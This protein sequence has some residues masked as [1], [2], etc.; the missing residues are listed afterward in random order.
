MPEVIV[1]Q[2]N[3]ARQEELKCRVGAY[4]R[5]SSDSDDQLNSFFNQVQHYT[6]LIKSNPEWEY[7]DIYAD[8]GVTGTRADKRSD[9]NRMI[10]DCEDGKLDK[11]ITKSISRFARNAV[12]CVKILKHLK[13]FGVSVIFEEDH[14][15][16]SNP[17]DFTMICAK[18]SLAEE[19][20]KSIAENVRMGNRFR[21]EEGT[22]VQSN[23]PIGFILKDKVLVIN[24]E[25]AS[26]IKRI[27]DSYLAGKSTSRI[28]EELMRDRIPNKYGKVHWTS[29]GISYIIS[30]VR[31]KGDAILQKSFKTGFP[32]KQVPNNGEL[33]KFYV[34][35]DNEPIVDESTY[36]KAN[37]LLQARQEKHAHSSV[38]K[39][40][41][42][43]RKIYCKECKTPYR[44][45]SDTDNWVCRTHDRNSD[46]CQAMPISE[47]M[48]K[49]AFVQMYNK[50]KANYERILLPFITQAESIKVN[51]AEKEQIE[52]LNIKIAQITEQVL[53]L[54]NLNGK[55]AIDPAFYI[56]E[57]NRHDNEVMK[58]RAIKSEI[59][60]NSQYDDI[61]SKTRLLA[62]EM[63]TEK[64]LAEFSED[65]F[66]KII[67][68]IE[69]DGKIIAF[70]LV[71]GMEFTI[72][73]EEVL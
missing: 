60:H 27:F 69:L 65:K 10:K 59:L 40:S 21:M 56:S 19:Q 26:V 13:N 15:D 31:Y 14:L 11:I 43:A 8:E 47:E 48:I 55:G 38:A 46:K 39:N 23:P 70:I 61:I 35:N 44:H 64:A 54:R 45:K 1:V 12:D 58:L 73:K 72:T 9:F 29:A 25:Q 50:L 62:S 53:T 34:H 51:K 67:S 20:S 4:A 57:L 18:A 33:P 5:V 68:K 49:K 52:E 16:S 66:K 17:S 28:A 3:L 37:A 63:E 7:V 71:N 22:Y 36:D 2:G 41:I 32:Y 24:E 30:N 6:K 42:F